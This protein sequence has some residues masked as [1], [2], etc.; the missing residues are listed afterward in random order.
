MI[1]PKATI[2]EIIGLLEAIN[3]AGGVEHAAQLAADFNLD[4]DEMLPSIDAAELLEFVVVTDGSIELTGDAQKLLNSSIR[5]RKKIIKDKVANVNIIK[6]LKNKLMESDDNKMSKE[7][8][9]KF[10]QKMIPNTNIE[11]YFNIIINW[12][13]H[14]GFFGYNSDSEEIYLM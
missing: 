10:L 5:E 11:S 1:F 12:T 4:L 7:D 13:R 9:I 6:E 2:S 14:I 3:D 8:A